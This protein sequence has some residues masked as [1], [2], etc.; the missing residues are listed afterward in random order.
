MRATIRHCSKLP[1]LRPEN[2][3]L[4]SGNGHADRLVSQLVQLQHRVP[5]V[6]HGHA[7]DPPA[8]MH[9]LLSTVGV[10]GLTPASRFAS[11]GF[12]VYTAQ[13][14]HVHRTYSDSRNYPEHR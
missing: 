6:E 8:I 4:L 10:P 2:G 12:S 14:T 7:S 5:V 13:I 3:D 11:T 9:R 1:R